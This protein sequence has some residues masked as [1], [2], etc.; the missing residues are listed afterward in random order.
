MHQNSPF[1]DQKP[2]KF[3]GRGHPLPTPHPLGASNLAPSA[4]TAPLCFFLIRALLSKLAGARF[5]RTCTFKSASNCWIK[6]LLTLFICLIMI[7]F[8]N[9]LISIEINH[10]IKVKKENTILQPRSKS[11]DL[12]MWMNVKSAISIVQKRE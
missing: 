2:K 4:L 1:P 7:D 3:L 8:E 12:Q 11:R 10:V 9:R 5:G 6:L